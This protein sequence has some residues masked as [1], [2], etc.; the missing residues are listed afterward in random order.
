MA[1]KWLKIYIYSLNLRRFKVS[2]LWS[3]KIHSKSYL[4]RSGCGKTFFVFCIC[5][6]LLLLLGT[7]Q[8]GS[9]RAR[10]HDSLLPASRGLDRKFPF[11]FL[12]MESCLIFAT[13]DALA[14]IL[15]TLCQQCLYV[16]L[17]QCHITT[18]SSLKQKR[19]APCKARSKLTKGFIYLQLIPTWQRE[20]RGQIPGTLLR[21]QEECGE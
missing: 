1:W 18:G 4:S 19:R 12:I 14:G 11:V 16:A 21:G 13:R 10:E 20:M 3:Q 5:T 6:S 2:L 7:T 9:W 8:A 17:P 15:Q